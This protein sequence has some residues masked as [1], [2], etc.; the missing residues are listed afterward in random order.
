MWKSKFPNGFLKS[1]TAIHL[2][3][4]NREKDIKFKK[5]IIRKL[6]INERKYFLVPFLM[7]TIIKQPSHENKPAVKKSR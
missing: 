6:I 4:T 5:S 1:Y 7:D 3:N 2:Y